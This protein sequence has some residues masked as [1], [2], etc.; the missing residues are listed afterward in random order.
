MEQQS[1]LNY[2]CD[3]RL[4]LHK[5]YKQYDDDKQWYSVFVLLPYWKG[6]LFPPERKEY[7]VNAI[8]Q[9][10]HVVACYDLMKSREQ[11]D[12]KYCFRVHNLCVGCDQIAGRVQFDLNICHCYW[13]VLFLHHLK[14]QS[15]F[16]RLLTID[17]F[18]R[19]HGDW[20]APKQMHHVGLH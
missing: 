20:I 15:V 1:L 5:S 19:W 11:S 3:K 9:G 12:V 13:K 7:P 6:N 16:H 18:H 4:S 8:R 10:S 2:H 14:A 17:P